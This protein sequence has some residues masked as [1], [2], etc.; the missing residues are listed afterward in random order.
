MDGMP[1]SRSTHLLALPLLIG[2]RWHRS[3]VI[4]TFYR[5]PEEVFLAFPEVAEWDVSHLP[6]GE[7]VRTFGNCIMFQ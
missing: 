1:L 7:N 6:A 5:F 3:P 4:Y 2:A